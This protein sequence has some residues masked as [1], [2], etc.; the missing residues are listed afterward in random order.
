MIEEV[1]LREENNMQELDSV[2]VITEKEKYAMDGVHK[3]MHGWICDPRTIDGT[4]LVNFP[5]YGENP[6]I[7]T[8]AILEKDLKKIPVMN[9]I[10]NEE[11]KA[12]FDKMEALSRT[13][14]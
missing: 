6:D 2:E 13:E 4:W 11:I 10:R 5:Q 14:E 8:I 3:G 12:E 7:A 9:A 1:N